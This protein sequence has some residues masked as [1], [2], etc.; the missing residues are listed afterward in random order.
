[1]I[2]S[3]MRLSLIDKG[4]FIFTA[5]LVSAIVYNTV[6]TVVKEMRK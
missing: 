6:E 4:L 1:M 3:F 2:E 5:V